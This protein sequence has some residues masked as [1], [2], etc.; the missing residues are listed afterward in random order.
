RQVDFLWM[1]I[2][3]KG[4]IQPKDWVAC[5]R[6][7]ML[8]HAVNAHREIDMPARRACSG[9]YKD[10]SPGALKVWGSK[11]RLVR[12]GAH[13]A[14]SS[15]LPL[16]YARYLSNQAMARCQPSLAASSR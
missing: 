6:L 7:E 10:L 4:V 9:H 11:P 8:E 14:V 15:V 3:V 5:V 12:G 1:G 13:Q 2:A 16:N